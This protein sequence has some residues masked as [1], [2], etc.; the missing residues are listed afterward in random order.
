MI[1]ILFD[2]TDTDFGG[3]GICRLRDC[4]SCTV[5]E[6]RNSGLYECEFEYPINGIN[7]DLI[8]C[9]RIIL[10]DHD[11]TGDKQAFDIIS[12]T[13]AINGVVTFHAVHI[14]YRLNKITANPKY[15]TSLASAINAI[16]D[17]T[18]TNQFNYSADFQA[19]GYLP[20]ADGVPKTV[21]SIIGGSEGSMLDTYG[22]EILW[23]G[24]NVKFLTS[25]GVDR[26]FTIR[27]GVNMTGYNEDIDF[28]GTYNEAIPYWTDG[29]KIVI[30]DVIK[31]TDTSYAG[32]E[33]CV[34]LDLSDRFSSRPTKSEVETY[35][36]MV[37][38]AKYPIMPEQTIKVEFVRLSDSPEYE[39]LKNLQKCE[40]CDTV[41]VVFPMYNLS[42]RFKIVKTE[43]NVLLDRYDSM[44]LGTLSTTLSQ[45]LGI[46]QGSD[47]TTAT[48]QLDAGI[49]ASAVTVSN[50]A[51]AT[52]DAPFNA[53]FVVAPV[54]VGILYDVQDNNGASTNTHQC[55]LQLKS[56]STTGATFN[57]R[58]NGTQ[59]RRVRVA[60]VAVG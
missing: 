48:P 52:I 43:Y 10:V 58:N 60:W 9:G 8:D 36:R 32:R 51:A 38:R 23:D 35:G 14:S 22:G 18:P 3:N 41:Q 53:E 50:G 28:S 25:R 37:L 34:P 44:E 59:T 26:D 21:R 20:V 17:A 46:Q 40:L 56:T 29:T 2:R 19:D 55:V 27:Y 30:G 16:E 1:P 45:A 5:T 47:G 31:L 33:E 57:V 13:N 15:I 24:W 49:T 4:I 39:N 54:V 7:Y 6:E 42:G 11:D 12:R